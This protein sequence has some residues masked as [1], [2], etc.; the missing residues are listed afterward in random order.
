MARY[1]KGFVIRASGFGVL[2]TLFAGLT[3]M[4]CDPKKDAPNSEARTDARS[5]KPEALFVDV[6]AASGLNFRYEIPGK[7]PLNILQAMP[8]GCAFLDYDADGNLD[9]LLISQRVALYRGDGKGQF[10]DVTAAVLPPLATGFWMGVAV[11][12][13]DNDGFDDVYLSA[14]RGGVLLHNEAGNPK[15]EK[16]TKKDQHP[17]FVDVSKAAGI[18]AQPF[19]TSAAFGDYDNDGKLDLYIGN[20]VKFGPDSVQHCKVKDIVTSCSPTIYDAEKGVLYRNLGGGKFRDVTVATGMDKVTGKALGVLFLD[21]DDSGRQSLYLA[22]DE[23]S[24]DLMHNL[25]GKL[26]GG[27]FENI[28]EISG[29]AYNEVGKPYGGMGVDYGDVDRDGKP[30]L[31]VGTFTVEN[32]MVLINQGDRLFVDKSEPLGVALPA[33]NYLSFGAQLFDFDNDGDLDLIFANGYIADNVHEYEPTRTYRE[34]TLLFQNEGGSRFTDISKTSGEAL[35]RP[36][37][38]RGLAVGDYDNDGKMDVLIVDGEGPPLL[39]HNES[40]RKNN[41]LSLRLIGAK[42]NRNAYG[43]KITVESASGKATYYC[44]TDGS[45]LSASD[46]RVHIGLGPATAAKLTL[47]WPNGATQTLN[48]KEVN[49]QITIEQKR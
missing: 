40:P 41:Y 1:R 10:S 11:G 7:R 39:L 38:G 47:R 30:D 13:Y 6:A 9:I 16:E 4:G 44:H 45:Y 28:G 8:G 27:R 19:G 26:G 22:N 49:R 43:T 24:S 32:K 35:T 31:I 17:K 5:P 14:Y 3:L 36:I 34:P 21:L 33:R 48:V 12:D 20:Y 37:V 23:V 46:S 25:G 15:S 42:G 29:V 2:V 18:T